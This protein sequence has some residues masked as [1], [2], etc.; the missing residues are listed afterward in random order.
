MAITIEHVDF[1]SMPT[2]DLDRARRFYLETLG[3]PLEHET[4]VGIEVRAGQVTLGVWQPEQV[5]LPFAPNP[6]DV[7]LRVPDVAEARRELEA[8]GVE[9]RGE[10]VDT[11]V[12]HMAFFHDPD[13]NALMLHRRYAPVGPPPEG[14]QPR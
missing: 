11:G 7:A 1:I 13:G 14:A 8:A 4:P 9:F 2:Q 10:I 3:L 5:G 6:N 12:C